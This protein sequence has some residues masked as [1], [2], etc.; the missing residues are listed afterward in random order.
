MV[1]E[2]RRTW[3]LEVKFH[4]ANGLLHHSE[5]PLAPA[6]NPTEGEASLHSGVIIHTVDM[7]KIGLC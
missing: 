3:Q 7:L 4:Q 5:S 6:L 2:L 1:G